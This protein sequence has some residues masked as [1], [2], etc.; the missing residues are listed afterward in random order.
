MRVYES[1]DGLRWSV[2]VKVP[3]FSSAMIVF[4]HPDG[5][6]ARGDRYAWYNAQMPESQDPRARLT[7]GQVIDAL[8]DRDIARLYRRSMPVHTEWPGYVAS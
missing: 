5:E 3:S 6:T 1:P 8:S 2:E 4:K 7:P